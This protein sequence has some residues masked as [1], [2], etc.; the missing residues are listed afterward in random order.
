MDESKIL[1]EEIKKE[2]LELINGGYVKGIS[3]IWGEIA[4]LLFGS[5]SWP[6]GFYSKPMSNTG[7]MCT[8]H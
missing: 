8:Q 5:C 1:L 3:I 4:S 6:D 2:Q 7:H